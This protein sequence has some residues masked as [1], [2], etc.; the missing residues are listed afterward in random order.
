MK[1]IEKYVWEYTGLSVEVIDS[2]MESI[3]LGHT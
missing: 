3:L 2:G 1:K